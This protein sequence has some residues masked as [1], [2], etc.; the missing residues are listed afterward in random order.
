[1]RPRTLTATA[2]FLSTLAA[3]SSSSSTSS[4]TSSGASG[5]DAAAPG[6]VKNGPPAD[7]VFGG[8]RP[9]KVFRAPAGYD[10]AKPAPLVVV[11]HGYGANATAQNL[12]FNLGSIADREGFF[13]VAPEGTTDAT[14]KQFWNGT[15]VCCDF[16]KTGVDDVAYVTGL[17][18]EIAKYY[19]IDPKRVFLVGHSNGGAM[20]FRLGCDASDRFAAIVDLAGPFFAD[21]SL[22]KPKAPVALLHMH[23]TKDT[24]VSYAPSTNGRFPN[25]GAVATVTKW[26]ENNGCGPTADTSSPAMDLDNAI[27][28]AE[29][30]VSRYTGCRED[31]T[32]EL[33]TMEGSGHVPFDL[34]K[35]LPS[36]I[37]AFL[38]AHPKR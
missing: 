5:T 12:F 10:A 37:Y 32:V 36:R 35:D 19:A 18:D 3:C 20:S 4:S 25:P 17:V 1:M 13:L 28:G 8:S 22:C 21:A 30:K 34:A 11:L 7:H 9:V 38:S 15:D 24:T 29:T 26:A 31:A 14:G 23:G 6:E 16:G 33:W 2:L 27:A